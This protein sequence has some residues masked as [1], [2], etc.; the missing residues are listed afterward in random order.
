MAA[1]GPLLSVALYFVLNALVQPLALAGAPAELTLA[2]GYLAELN[3]VLA[4]FNMVPAY[5]MDGGRVLRSLIW[6]FT[7]RLGMATRIAATLGQGFAV[8]LML[9]GA[10]VAVFNADIF[11]GLWRVVLGLM[12][13]R[14]A[15][16]GRRAAPQD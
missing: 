1:A 5:P 9:W 3:L 14:M 6:L 2:T 8:L 11:A 12:L 13:F 4:I 15:K 7:G 16:A 10:Y